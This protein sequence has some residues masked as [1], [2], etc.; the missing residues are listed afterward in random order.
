MLDLAVEVLPF[1]EG[2]AVWIR[3]SLQTQLGADEFED[4]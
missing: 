3:H 2:G 4:W 1:E